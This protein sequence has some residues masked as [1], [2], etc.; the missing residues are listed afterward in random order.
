MKIRIDLSAQRENQAKQT[1][2]L[3]WKIRRL[4]T[5]GIEPGRRQIVH[6]PYKC[7]DPDRVPFVQ[8]VKELDIKDYE[9]QRN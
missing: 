1:K 4:V 9:G 5:G 3:L 8:E 6:I 7:T 2:Q